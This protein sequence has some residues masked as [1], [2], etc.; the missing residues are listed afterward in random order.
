MTTA[1]ELE[2][3]WKWSRFQ[4]GASALKWNRRELTSLAAALELVQDR[5]VAVQAGGNLGI[6]PKA[7]AR[8]F[9]T[10][11]TFE[12]AP[13]LFRM[14]V[15]N[16]P[17]PNIVKF[18]AA[19]G[20]T[21]K[22]VGLSRERRDGKPDNHEGITHVAG[23]GNIPTLRLDALRLPVVSLLYLDV[24]GYELFALWGAQDTIR[25]CRPVIA[26]EINKNI[27]FLGLERERVRTCIRNFGY[28]PRGGVHS[29][30]FF[31]YEGEI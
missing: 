4:G 2:A 12:P 19:L 21:P 30:E 5:R 29:D 31:V 10:V 17:E 26:V 8:V 15:D 24:E 25:R 7:L 22:M 14:L 23:E 18:Q 20:D 27:E 28:A 9:D 13:D 16:A 1:A 11:Y 3:G 6:F